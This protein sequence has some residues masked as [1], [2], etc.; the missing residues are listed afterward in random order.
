MIELDIEQALGSQ[1]NDFLVSYP[2]DVKDPN[3]KYIPKCGIPYLE[4]NFLTGDQFQKTF[5]TI[6]MNRVGG[7]YQ[8][9]IN[10]QSNTGQG[11]I[12]EIYRAL[13]PFFK[14]GTKIIYI[15]DLAETVKVT[16]EK[17]SM[18]TEKFSSGPDWFAKI[19]N[20]Q[21]RSDIEN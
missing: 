9:D 2:I 17:M 14:R 3:I 10:I 16:I 4:V 13:K 11:K 20:I 1:L 6:A 21:W 15:N 8:I 5:G 19:I 18:A 12:K 7:I